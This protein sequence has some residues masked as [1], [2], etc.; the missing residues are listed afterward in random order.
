MTNDLS[1]EELM[2]EETYPE[3][4]TEGENWKILHG[5]TLK[6]VKAF[7]PGIFDADTFRRQET[8]GKL[9][10]TQLRTEGMAA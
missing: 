6:L 5:D 10:W 9:G 1:L 8:Q 7:Q 4:Y 2:K 3:E